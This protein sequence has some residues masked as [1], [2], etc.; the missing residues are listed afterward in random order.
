[1]LPSPANGPQLF[2]GLQG[3]RCLAKVPRGTGVNCLAEVPLLPPLEPLFIPALP[4]FFAE[5][6]E[7]SQLCKRPWLSGACGQ[8]WHKQQ[9]LTK[10]KILC[11]LSIK[12][13]PSLQHLHS[14]CAIEFSIVY[15]SLYRVLKS[16][17][18]ITQSESQSY[19]LGS[20]TLRIT[21][22]FK[23]YSLSFP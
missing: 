1:M 7:P 6:Y 19:F 18:L 22:S 10:V 21:Y 14:N 16:K 3:Q 15:R 20:I 17:H 9:S 13:S 5:A 12:L 23:F 2:W 11:S 8:S 4:C